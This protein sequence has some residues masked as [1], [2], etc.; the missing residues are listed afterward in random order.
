MEGGPKGGHPHAKKFEYGI[1]CLIVL[2]I[3]LIVCGTTKMLA[4][5]SAFHTWYMVIESLS[6]VLFSLEYGLR[7]WA[8]VEEDDFVEDEQLVTS[9]RSA[10]APIPRRHAP[11]ESSTA[12]DAQLSDSFS[13]PEAIGLFSLALPPYLVPYCAVITVLGL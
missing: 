5:S 8:C 13:S 11:A 1:L 12:L 10:R 3:V 9:A 6:L 4:N 7:V 2:N